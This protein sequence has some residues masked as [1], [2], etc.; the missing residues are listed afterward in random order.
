[1]GP[2]IGGPTA[3]LYRAAARLFA[4]CC[5]P[6]QIT[7]HANAAIADHSN[8]Q[9]GFLLCETDVLRV[10][11]DRLTPQMQKSIFACHHEDQHSHTDSGYAQEELEKAL[12]RLAVSSLRRRSNLSL[13]SGPF[14]SFNNH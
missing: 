1:M 14:R 9:L 10:H 6:W 7:K 5:H 8:G 4:V 11:S 13:I 3:S 12:D 2:S